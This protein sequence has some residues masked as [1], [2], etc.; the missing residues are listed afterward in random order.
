MDDREP[1]S[2]RYARGLVHGA[3][4]L[5]LSIEWLFNRFAA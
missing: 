1:V 3:L 2:S 4:D 5:A